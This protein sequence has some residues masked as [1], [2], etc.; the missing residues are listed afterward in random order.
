M[1]LFCYCTRVHPWI[2]YTPLT[3]KMELVF[4]SHTL[5][6]AY[7]IVTQFHLQTNF[8]KKSTVTIKKKLRVL[9]ST[10]L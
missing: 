9:I 5:L 10:Q 6:M 2:I 3:Y 7:L 8:G 4:L 1:A